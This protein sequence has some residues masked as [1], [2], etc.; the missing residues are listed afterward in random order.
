M[1]RLVLILAVLLLVGCAERQTLEPRLAV[2][3]T[4]GWP[5]TVVDPA[6]DWNPARHELVAR[7]LGGFSLLV[8]GAQGERR[9]AAENRRESHLPRW[10]NAEQF[11]FGPGHGAKRSP[12]GTVIVPSDGLTV[13]TLAGDRPQRRA[14]CNRGFRPQPAGGGLV[15]AQEAN[16]VLL[17]DDQGT[18]RDFGEGF[19]VV[20]QRDGPGLC[21]RDVPA[22]DPDWW[23]GKPWPGTLY[24]RWK[25]GAVD[26][27]PAAVQA[28][29]TRH[30]EVV[31]TVVAG[32][33]PAGQPW[34]AAGTR[35]IHLAGPGAA[36]VELRAGARDPVPHP[37]A[38]LLAWVGE[39]GGVWMG[40]L[41]P[42]GWSERVTDAGEAPRWSHDGLRLCWLAPPEPG[43]QLPAIR[44]GVLAVR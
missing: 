12:D 2:I 27:V 21:W 10:L 7:S 33:A 5:A 38:D 28:A 39:D 6:P 14:L 13:V 35:L 41:R 8:E 16:R 4:F 31:C 3:R 29:W 43:S 11:V 20:A 40:T 44:V 36:P 34:W 19:D 24:V 18:V 37:T 30:G 26:A 23:T 32:P 9:F 17:I 22:F 15:A 1:S 25:P 42:D